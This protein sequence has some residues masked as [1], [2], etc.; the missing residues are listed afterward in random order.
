M[1]TSK[2]QELQEAYIRFQESSIARQTWRTC[3]NC[4]H[5]G[6]LKGIC[7]KFEATPPLKVVVVG[8]QVWEG[9]IPF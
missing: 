9:E 6:T 3:L 2:R 4:E 1:N 8:C 5:W 7:N